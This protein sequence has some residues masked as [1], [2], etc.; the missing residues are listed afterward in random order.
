MGVGVGVGK[1]AV[2]DT[3]RGRVAGGPRHKEEGKGGGG[4]VAGWRIMT[5]DEC[6]WLADRGIKMGM[7]D[8]GTRG[9]GVEGG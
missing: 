5:Q 3:G 6:E 2:R 1:V 4:D 8:H 9:E 7:A